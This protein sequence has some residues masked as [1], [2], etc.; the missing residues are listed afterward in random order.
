VV[1]NAGYGVLGTAEELSD[2]QI[3]GLL[4]TN[5][6]GSIQLIRAVVPHLRARGGGRILQMSSMGGQMAFPG[7]SL[8][9]ASKWG[10]EGFVEAVAPEVEPFG[11]RTTLVEPGMIRT[12]FYAAVER[13]EPLPEYADNPLL[14]RGGTPVE[15]MPGDQ[16]KVAAAMIEVAAAAD[17][18]RRLLLGSDAHRLVR[19]ALAERLAAADAQRDSAAATDVDGISPVRMS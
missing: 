13:T 16:A 12:S 4:A 14:T 19:D 17:P 7:F 5:L 11:I 15:A 10:I 8:Y 9:H 18:P 3:D 6:T 2:A 1:S